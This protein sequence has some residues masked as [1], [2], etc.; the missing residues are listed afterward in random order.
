MAR[1]PTKA[2]L[3]EKRTYILKM[4][5]GELRKMTFPAHWRLTFGN[6]LPYQGKEARTSVEHR[7]AL[8]IYGESKDDLRAVMLDV[9][10]FRDASIEVLDRRTS[11][12]RKG[13]Q[14]QT[15][16]GKK[17]VVYEA[18]MQ[19]WVNPDKEDGSSSGVTEYKALEKR[20]LA[21][22]DQEPL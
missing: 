21:D 3:D 13:A 18:R 19:E 8:R 5:N 16:H 20:S 9:V 15:E 4:K 12:Q 22:D 7:I 10:D 2:K 17:D 14:V 1:R 6:V 11:V